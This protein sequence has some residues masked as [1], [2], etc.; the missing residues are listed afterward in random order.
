MR[1]ITYRRPAGDWLD[2]LPLGDGRTG[3]MVLAATDGVRLQLND[4]TAWSGSPASEHRHGPVDAAAAAEARA[5][6]RHLLDDGRAVE[7][8]RALTALQARYA[9]A[10]LPFADVEIRHVPAAE[11]ERSLDLSE[12]VHSAAAGQVRHTTFVSAPDGVVVHE[13]TSMQPIEVTVTAHSPLRDLGSTWPGDGFQLLLALPADVAPSHEPA[14]PPLRWNLA[15]V[16]P[17]EGAVVARIVHDGVADAATG[18]PL[19]RLRD[20]RTLRLVLATQTTFTG[21]GRAPCGDAR[22][23]AATAQQRV[24]DALDAGPEEVRARHVAAHQSLYSRVSLRLGD[25]EQAT[26]TLVDPDR[27]IA[28]LGP[29]AAT[30]PELLETLFDYGRYLLISASRPGGLP[31]TLQGLWNEQMQPPWSSAYTLNIN[32]E[33]NYWP[34]GPLGLAE[35]G[36]PLFDLVEALA[37]SGTETARRLYGA[38]GWTAHHNTDAW[39]FTSP[40]SG[41][42]SWSQWA[43]GGVWLICQIDRHRRFGAADEAWLERFWPLVQGAAAFVLDLLEEDADGFLVSF[44]S[45]S[46]ENRYATADGPAALTVGSGMDR[47]LATELFAVLAEV[48]AHLGRSGDPVVVEAAAARQRIRPPGIEA[49]GTIREWHPGARSVEPDHRH[50][51]HLV[52]AYPGYAL[53]DGLAAALTQTLD[54]R[55]DDSTGW[56][57]AWKLALRARLG[58]ADR[59]AELLRYLVRPAVTG[60]AHAGGLYA[61]LFAAHPPFQIDGNLGYTAAICEALV[62]GHNGV[63]DLLPAWP[64]ML[65]AGVVRGL[66]AEPGITVYLSWRNGVPVTVSL[67]ALSQ[68]QAGPRLVRHAGLSRVVDISADRPVTVD[69]SS[70]TAPPPRRNPR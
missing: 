10:Y 6:A 38:R 46:P 39:A 44:P 53:D 67:Q 64:P 57:L 29:A 55:G 20:V 51:S 25:A 30:D 58:D 2:G 50:L 4:G 59:V 21:I 7:A 16:E 22:Q 27:R 13:L 24:T 52:F 41:D 26:D 66:V 23:A 3:V 40:T 45:T 48:A 35:T 11:V 5:A 69:W 9:Q 62:Q 54:A 60:V 37:A 63:V 1:R 32:T 28:E 8:E 65:D 31:A 68:R 19:T 12:A 61:N 15:G 33:M 14:E 49:D 17:V 34:A 18:G 70:L 47:A 36:Q 56:S 43:M 42:A